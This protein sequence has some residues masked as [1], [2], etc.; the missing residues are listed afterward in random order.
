MA[1]EPLFDLELLGYRNDVARER[2]L[3]Q[4]RGRAGASAL[5]AIDRDTPLPHRLSAGL[6]H[7]EGLRLLGTLRDCGAHVRLVAVASDAE[8]APPPPSPPAAAPRPPREAPRLLLGVILIALLA[9]IFLQ[10][11]PRQRPRRPPA[12]AVPLPLDGGAGGAAATHRLNDEAVELNAA[13]RFQAA[14]DRLRTALAGAPDEAA[15]RR[16]L[17]TVLQNWAVAE[18]N[19]DHPADAVPLLE[20]ALALDEDAVVLSALGIAHVRQGD[21]QAGREMLE[22]ATAQGARDPA[23]LTALGNAYRQLGA[24]ADAVDALHRAREAGARGAD[25]DALVTRAEREMDAEWDFDETRSAHFTI[26]F[27]GGER[28]SQAAADLVGRGLESAYFGVGN[29][30]DLYPGE[31]IPVVLYASEDFHDVTQTPSWSAGVY[32]G[33]IKLPVGGLIESDQ[34]V[35]TRTLRHEYGHVLVHQLARGRAPVWLNEGVAIWSEEERDGDRT[36]WALQAIAGQPLFHLGELA[37]PFTAQPPERVPVAYA[38][39]YLAVHALV[40]RH[41]AR[42]LRTL[43]EQLGAGAPFERAFRDSLYADPA[44]FE[45]ELL[46][47]LAG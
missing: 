16:N 45:Q 24:R 25:F 17:R 2:V 36:D 20:E 12:A 6:T 38:Q 43:L 21:F 40:D 30:L 37:G 23:T 46:R 8:P 13:G 14:A 27:A 34:E 33:R 15:L 9:A 42:R 39:S 47:Q 4:L 22:R 26:G 28:E 5:T 11:L 7:A 10:L 32:D 19:A 41:G 31:R 18:L 1:G 3:A 35:L 44:A 29:K